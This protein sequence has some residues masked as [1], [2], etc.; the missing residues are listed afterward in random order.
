[1]SATKSVNIFRCRDLYNGKVVWLVDTP[2]FDDTLRSDIEILEEIATYL[3]KLYDKGVRF[4]G[5][6]YLQRITDPRMSGTAIKNLEL[7]KLV[8]GE[9]A[10]TMARLITTRW[11]EVVPGSVEYTG[12][13]EREE[14]LTTNPKYFKPLL[15]GGA[16][17]LR[18]EILTAASGKAV[19]YSVVASEQRLTL[20]IQR[21]MLNGRM[22]LGQTS[23]GQYLGRESAALTKRYEAEL[24]EIQES[25][26]DALRERDEEAL[27][28]LRLEQEQC[29]SRRARLQRDQQDMLADFQALDARKAQELKTKEVDGLA[30][31]ENSY[32]K[33]EEYNGTQHRPDKRLSGGN[34][35]SIDHAHDP[36]ESRRARVKQHMSAK[37]HKVVSHDRWHVRLTSLQE[38]QLWLWNMVG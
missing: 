2:G 11:N 1:M 7:F 6:L 15:Q 9:D 33:D 38:V 37:W 29:Q 36:R 28:M 5:L 31:P 25:L 23:A 18:H 27:A 20:D 30:T 16:K 24:R 35:M 3:G 32:S 26:A 22:T 21:E 10:Y 34:M 12:C 14:Q 8:C 17:L 4:S 19:V 13:V